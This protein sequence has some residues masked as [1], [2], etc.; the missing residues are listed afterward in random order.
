[1]RRDL[2]AFTLIKPLD[3]VRAWVWRDQKLGL[4]YKSFGSNIG[5]TSTINNKRANLP[6]HSTL[7]VEDVR[8][9]LHVMLGSNTTQSSSYQKHFS[10]I[11]SLFNF[12][13]GFGHEKLLSSLIILIF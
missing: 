13:K 1:M 9:L 3:G 10:F 2:Q 11:G 4:L 12:Y 7:G 6:L 8:P 5:I